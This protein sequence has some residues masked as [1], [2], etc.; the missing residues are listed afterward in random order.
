MLYNHIL[1]NLTPCHSVMSD[2]T[3]TD[4]WAFVSFSCRPSSSLPAKRVD[5]LEIRSTN[6][7]TVHILEKLCSA[8]LWRWYYTFNVLVCS[9]M[10]SFLTCPGELGFFCARAD[11]KRD[12]R[13]GGL[14]GFPLTKSGLN[15]IQLRI[16]TFR[17]K[18]SL[19]MRWTTKKNLYASSDDTFEDMLATSNNYRLK[20]CFS[21]VSYLQI[22]RMHCA[23]IS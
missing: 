7:C 12:I 3:L 6:D 1:E 22:N 8:K 13:V 20:F 21:T 15:S 9:D 14:P 16:P 4:T 10:D 23:K 19:L 5:H 18:I 11:S 17:H 2:S